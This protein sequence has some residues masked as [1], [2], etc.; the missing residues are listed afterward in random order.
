MTQVIGRTL[1]LWAAA[2]QVFDAL[3]VVA[4]GALGGA[5]DT[6]FVMWGVIVGTWLVQVPLGWWLGVELGYGAAGVWAAVAVECALKAVIF[7]ERWR[8]GGWRGRAVVQR[9]AELGA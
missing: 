9:S 1:L 4:M 3:C 8:R 6:R 2:F 7:G 5:G